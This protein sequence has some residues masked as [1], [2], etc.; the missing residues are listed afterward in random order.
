M[1]EKINV[2][3]PSLYVADCGDTNEHKQLS[4]LSDNSP[5]IIDNDMVYKFCVGES[6]NKCPLNCKNKDCK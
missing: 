2:C 6:F 1:S 3:C 4:C 5:M